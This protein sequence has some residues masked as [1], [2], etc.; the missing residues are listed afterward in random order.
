V[1]SK[2]KMA[3]IRMRPADHAVLKAYADQ[4]GLSISD[5]VIAYAKS[6]RRKLTPYGKQRLEELTKAEE[7]K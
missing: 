6:L 4:E 5:V 2:D 1:A 3:N 7:G